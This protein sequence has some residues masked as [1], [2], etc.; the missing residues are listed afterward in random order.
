MPCW[1]E[2]TFKSRKAKLNKNKSSQSPSW[3][4][5]GWTSLRKM[6]TLCKTINILWTKVKQKYKSSKMSVW[7][8]HLTNL[9]LSGLER[10]IYWERHWRS[11]R[12]K[13]S[14][15]QSQFDTNNVCSQSVRNDSQYLQVCALKPV[16]VS[17]SCFT[18]A[19]SIHVHS[20]AHK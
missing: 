2:E 8:I 14:L 15:N 3:P 4:V 11:V 17:W 12:E 20:G 9:Y 7:F 10:L 18:S 13:F 5:T 16:R 6:F 1:T 19:G